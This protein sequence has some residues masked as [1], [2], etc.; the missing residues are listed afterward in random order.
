MGQFTTLHRQIC[1]LITWID[2]CNIVVAAGLG[3][4][5]QSDAHMEW[6][7]PLLR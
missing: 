1:E 4:H 2:S 5:T 7:L 6:C 3:S